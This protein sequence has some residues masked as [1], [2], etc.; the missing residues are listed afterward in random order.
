[1]KKSSM[2]IGLL[3]LVLTGCHVTVDRR[4]PCPPP[5]PLP[6]AEQPPQDDVQ[7]HLHGPL[8]FC[9][10]CGVIPGNISNCPNYSSHDFGSVP[11][12]TVVVCKRCGVC[13]TSAPTRCPSYSSHDFMPIQPGTALVCTRC[14][15]APT[16]KPVSCPNYSSHDF[17]IFK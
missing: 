10:R 14:G 7:Q 9:K 2:V 15:A 12:G 1:M 11:A 8:V 6:S 5:Y 16:D 3:L 13:A 17:K 4:T